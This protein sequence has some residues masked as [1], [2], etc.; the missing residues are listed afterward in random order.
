VDARGGW[1]LL[2]EGAAV[3][4]A[5]GEEVG[6]SRH[7][8]LRVRLIGEEAPEGWMV[9]AELVQGAIA[10]LADGVSELAD[11]LDKPVAGHLLEVGVEVGRHRRLRVVRLYETTIMARALNRCDALFALATF[12]THRWCAAP[13]PPQKEW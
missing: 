11:F 2:V 6:P 13:P 1:R 7:D 8:G 10:M 4:D 3:A 5:A 12:A 9:P